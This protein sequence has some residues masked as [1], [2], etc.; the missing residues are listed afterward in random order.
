MSKR[1]VHFEHWD[2]GTEADSEPPYEVFCGTE[3]EFEQKHF[4][5]YSDRVTCKRCLKML[6]RGWPCT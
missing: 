6:R 5:R 4:T 1:K 3:G 2:G